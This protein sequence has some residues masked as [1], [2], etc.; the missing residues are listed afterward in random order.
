MNT[1]RPF[2]NLGIEQLEAMAVDI[3]G[4]HPTNDRLLAELRHRSTQRAQRLR[5]KLEEMRSL[6]QTAQ[7]AFEKVT[8]PSTPPGLSSKATASTRPLPRAEALS[9]NPASILRAWTVLEVLS[10]ATFRTP[11]DL[12]GGDAR[13][14]ARFDRGLPWEGGAAKG[15]QGT[16][17]YFQIVLGSLAMQPAMEQLLQRFADTRPERPKV[18]GETPLAIVIVDREG[19]PLP[20][21]CAVVSS[22]AW[23]LPKALRNDPATLS[24]WHRSGDDIQKGLHDRLF[25]EQPDGKPAVL[26]MAAITSAFTWLSDTLGVDRAMVRPP[27]FAVRSLVSFRAR[28]ESC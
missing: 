16:R 18:S 25:R 4:A 6:A 17:L 7:V 3:S 1:S 27:S 2:A 21:G 13:R 19:R 9:N 5:C 11:S 28:P 8:A 26:D 12:A 23:G 22:F 14:V 15:P 24:E 20:D 10:P